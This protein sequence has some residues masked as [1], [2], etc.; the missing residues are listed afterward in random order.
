MEEKVR[1]LRGIIFRWLGGAHRVLHSNHGVPQYLLGSIHRTLFLLLLLSSLR[2]NVHDLTSRDDIYIYITL[3]NHTINIYVYTVSI[4]SKRKTIIQIITKNRKNAMRVCHCF[5]GGYLSMQWGIVLN[6]FLLTEI[7]HLFILVAPFF[8]DRDD[9]IYIYIA[10][11]TMN[12]LHDKHY[13]LGQK[14][15]RGKSFQYRMNRRAFFL[16]SSIMETTFWIVWGRWERKIYQMRRIITSCF[17]W[18]I[19]IYM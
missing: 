11:R 9:E 12:I 8:E 18:K 1:T 14:G 4:V 13:A 19:S 2:I 3:F 5:Y 15:L 17:K 16:Q 10:V 6:V 7:H